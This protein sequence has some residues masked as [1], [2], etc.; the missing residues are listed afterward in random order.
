MFL[1]DWEVV[2]KHKVHQQLPSNIERLVPHSF[3]FM[4]GQVGI[5]VHRDHLTVPGTIRTQETLRKRR[6][7]HARGLKVP[8]VSSA[9]QI[10]PSVAA[11][12]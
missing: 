12:K 7:E 3:G 1:T 6:K 11:Y 8:S 10:L 2:H 5:E 9:R 4:Q